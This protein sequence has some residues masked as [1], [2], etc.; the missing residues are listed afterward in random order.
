MDDRE[1]ILNALRVIK[2]TCV[3][4]SC[5]SCSLRVKNAKNE[6]D[7]CQLTHEKPYRWEIVEET[8]IWRAFND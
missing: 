2:D 8:G 1:K 3:D 6:D 7:Q 4:N 5:D